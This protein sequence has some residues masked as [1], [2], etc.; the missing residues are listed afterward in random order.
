MLA[1]APL[2]RAHAELPQPVR[3]MIEAAMATG[4]PRKVETVVEIARQ[5]NPGETDEIDTLAD[6]F[7]TQ[8][9]RLAAE[10][11]ARKERELRQA[12]LF[13]NWSGR[14]ELGATR[15]TGN[16][17]ETGVTA[18][19]ALTRE[20]INWTHKLLAAIDYQRTSGRTSKE[21]L[22]FSYEPNYN[23]SDRL[24]AYGLEQYERDRFQG[25]SSR[26]SVSGGLGYHAIDRKRMTLSLK[27][28]PAWRHTNYL[29]TPTEDTVAALAALDFDWKIG[30]GLSLTQDASA[31][32]ESAN[33]TLTSAT[34]FE[35]KINRRL[36]ARLSYTVEHDTDPPESAEENGHAHPFHANLRF[37]TRLAARIRPN[38]GRERSKGD[39]TPIQHG[40]STPCSYF[41][42]R[43]GRGRFGLMI[44]W[45]KQE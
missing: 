4:D 39:S 18:R 12:G 6:H 42:G 3:A 26:V 23:I 35:T 24:F 14:G 41:E 45:R 7:R 43:A 16:T 40:S 20:G 19:L 13:D 10:A 30:D 9:Q 27:G 36:A 44:S 33:S 38:P 25:F 28:G 22:L 29:D 8:R 5:T 32:L 31:Y 34:G 2:S 21:Q 37:L 1:A 15:S 11:A 17:T